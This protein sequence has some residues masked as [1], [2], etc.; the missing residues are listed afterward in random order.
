TLHV[1]SHGAARRLDLSCSHT[2]AARRL[3]AELAEGH[4]AAALRQAAVAALE[5]LAVLG[6]LGL[7]HG[8][9]RRGSRRRRRSLCALGR[10][11]LELDLV[12]DLALEDPDLDA[13]DAVGRVSLGESVVDVGSERVQRNATFAV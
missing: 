1:A 10:L 12:E 13:D 2:S 11:S 9:S 3:Q 5:H 8:L 4:G 6:A 7:Q